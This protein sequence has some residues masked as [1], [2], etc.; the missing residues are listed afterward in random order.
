MKSKTLFVC[1]IFL[2]LISCSTKEKKENLD[3]DFLKNDKNTQKSIWIDTIRESKLVKTSQIELQ[4]K[5]VTDET[6]T[7]GLN[8]PLQRKLAEEAKKANIDFSL[9]QQDEAVSRNK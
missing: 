7:R 1:S 5:T 2:I 6:S 9:R 8:T 3:L 4:N